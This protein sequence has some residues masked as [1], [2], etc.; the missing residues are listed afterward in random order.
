[1]V[2]AFPLGVSVEHKVWPKAAGGLKS[3]PC[4]LC[5]AFW[6]VCCHLLA[7]WCRWTPQIHPKSNCKILVLLHLILPLCTKLSKA[8]WQGRPQCFSRETSLKLIML[9]QLREIIISGC[10][11]PGRGFCPKPQIQPG[12]GCPIRWDQAAKRG[13]GVTVSMFSSLFVCLKLIGDEIS[14][15]G[16]L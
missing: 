9:L 11:S 1:M 13:G 2:A 8:P 3:L 16:A 14:S 7:W 4:A 10:F 6:G 15:Q 12:S 5:S